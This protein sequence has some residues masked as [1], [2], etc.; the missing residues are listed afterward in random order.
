MVKMKLVIGCMSIC[1]VICLLIGCTL[2]TRHDKTM[3]QQQMQGTLYASF[4]IS[5]DGRRIVFSGASSKGRGL[6]LLEVQTCEVTRLTDPSGYENYP[7]FSP[8]GKTIVYQSALGL[9]KPRYLFLRSLD[10]KRVQQITHTTNTQDSYP[11]FFRDGKRVA[12]ARAQ[13]FYPKARGENTWDNYDVYMINIDGK[14]LRRLTYGNYH[15][16]IRPK[17]YPDGKHILFEQTVVTASSSGMHL[18]KVNTS[19]SGTVQAVLRFGTFADFSPYFF[20]N[21]NQ[22]AFCSNSE[23]TVG[24]YKAVLNGNSPVLLVPDQSGAGASNPV[25]SPDGKSIYY[26]TVYNGGLWKV[27]ADGSNP[28][29]IADSG[30]FSDPMHWKSASTQ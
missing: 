24:L 11:F 15:G 12:F 20:Q 25:V 28:K 16:V 13:T 2:T 4:D 30:L 22:I 14:N 8:D 1:A 7:T 19:G 29:Q 6:Y 26:L 18:A 10:G 27:G 9:D 21:Q 5:P 3:P 23:G 17:P